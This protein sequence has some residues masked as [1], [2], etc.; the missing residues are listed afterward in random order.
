MCSLDCDTSQIITKPELSNADINIVFDGDSL[1]VG[2]G[3]SENYY[4]PNKVY[5]Y[6]YTV[7]NSVYISNY[8][9]SGQTTQ[10][11][12][13]DI[14]TQILPSVTPSKT[15]VI[16]AWEDVNAILNSG[17]TAQENYDDFVNY[18]SQC[19]GAGYD[20]CIMVIGYYPRTPYIPAWDAS[21]TLLD[22]HAEFLDM[23]ISNG[24]PNVDAIC[25]LRDNVNVGGSRGQ[26]MD[27]TYF[28]DTVHLLDSG[29][30]IVAQSVIDQGI[31][32]IFDI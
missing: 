7:C 3:S 4:Y 9:I 17:R 24:M 5:D 10:Q 16:V 11:M 19:K 1:T 8:A 26:A 13:S 27:A 6:L 32:T 12:L 28:F 22:V 29:Y 18:F 23:V 30:D 2:Y 21:P 14:S 15:N 20:Y 31:L 25:D